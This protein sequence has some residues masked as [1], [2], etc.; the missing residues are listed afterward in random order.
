MNCHSLFLIPG[1]NTIT[2]QSNFSLK[3]NS[4][5]VNQKKFFFF[6]LLSQWSS[7]LEF[8]CSP[9]DFSDCTVSISCSHLSSSSCLCQPL[10]VDLSKWGWEVT[11][12]S[13]GLVVENE[14]EGTATNRHIK[15]S[16][17]VIY[18]IL[19]T[20][21]LPWHLWHLCIYC[22]W[23]AHLPHRDSNH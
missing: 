4:F 12:S 14:E 10:V 20:G 3:V 9:L 17:L 15:H 2:F 19:T 8:W 22:I 23:R 7:S 16:C 18:L 6:G 21:M 5:Q 1:R 11:A 13:P